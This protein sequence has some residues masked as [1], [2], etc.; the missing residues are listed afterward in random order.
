M[1]CQQIHRLSKNVVQVGKLIFERS[2]R[3]ITLWQRSPSFSTS[4]ARSYSAAF[5]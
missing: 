3:S 2:T 5:W 1:G 4:P